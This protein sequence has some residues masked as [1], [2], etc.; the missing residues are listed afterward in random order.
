VL[1]PV[2]SD[3][4]G[5]PHGHTG[6]G[7][8]RVAFVQQGKIGLNPFAEKNHLAGSEL[9]FLFQ[10]GYEAERVSSKIRG[11]TRGRLRRRK[12]KG[13]LEFTTNKGGAPTGR[14]ERFEGCGNKG[15]ETVQPLAKRKP[16]HREGKPLGD[17]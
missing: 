16:Q 2:L 8:K 15:P 1:R 12:P 10:G 7:I 5:K 9:I 14:P 4:A 3:V 13:K 17:G 11:G 6:A